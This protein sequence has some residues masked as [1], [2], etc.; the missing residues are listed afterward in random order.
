M[1]AVSPHGLL[2]RALELY[3]LVLGLWGVYLYFRSNAVNGAYRASFLLMGGL[4]MVQGLLGAIAFAGGSRP[5][6]LLH[7]VYGIFAV[8]FIPGVYLY[9]QPPKAA[10][11]GSARREAVL[12]AGAAWIVLIAYFRGV[13]TG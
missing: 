4:T 1:T 9:A 11:A 10:K 5:H 8:I 6:T 2:A 12:L 3:A 7:L 13:S